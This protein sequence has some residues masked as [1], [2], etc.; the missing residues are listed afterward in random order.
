MCTHT[1]KRLLGILLWKWKE[2]G[3]RELVW[4]QLKYTT[5]TD[6]QC[7]T[8]EHQTEAAD[9]APAVSENVVS[10]QSKSTVSVV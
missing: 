5:V 3:D 2:N 8:S 1:Y 6:L 10:Q 7:L 9:H 4:L